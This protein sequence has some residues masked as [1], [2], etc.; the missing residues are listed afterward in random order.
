MKNR[1]VEITVDRPLGSVHPKHQNMIY[2]VNYGYVQG[3]IAPDGEEQDVY[4]LG[5]DK[6]ID[7]FRG[8]LIAVIHR[9]NDVEDKWVACPEELAFSKEEI[10][11]HVKF[12]EQYFDSFVEML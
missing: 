10:M 1:I 5:I 2:P 11:E 9:N 3:I 7:Q 12:T 8:K 6:P 4:I